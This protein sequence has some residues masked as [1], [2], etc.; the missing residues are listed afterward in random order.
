M[1]DVVDVL[2]C[3]LLLLFC[4]CVLFFSI[5]KMTTKD[6]HLVLDGGAGVFVD[7]CSADKMDY[8]VLLVLFSFRNIL[9]FPPGVAVQLKEGGNF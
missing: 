6:L 1:V 8:G 9:F 4:F 2:L 7:V 5:E 3:F